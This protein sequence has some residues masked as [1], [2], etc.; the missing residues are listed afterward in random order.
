MTNTLD[1]LQVR[2]QDYNKQIRDAE[3]QLGLLR[4]SYKTND[5]PYLDEQHKL[6][7]MIEFQKQLAAK[8]EASKF[9]AQSK[10]QGTN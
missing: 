8:M 3:A 5:Q 1:V 9:D 10:A 7:Q 6:E 2:Y 4:K